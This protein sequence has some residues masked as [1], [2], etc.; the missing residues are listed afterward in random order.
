MRLLLVSKTIDEARIFLSYADGC[1]LLGENKAQEA[2]RKCEA[3]ADL[4]DLN[5]VVIGHLQTNKAKLVARFAGEFQV[6]GNLRVAAEALDR[7]LQAE[8]RALC[9]TAILAH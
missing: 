2:H 4:T 9:Q 5:W 7:R 1:R 3:M 8:G 6:L